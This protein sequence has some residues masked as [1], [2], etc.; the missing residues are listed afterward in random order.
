[1]P[2]RVQTAI[3]LFRDVCTVHKIMI[4]RAEQIKSVSIAEAKL[5]LLVVFLVKID[6]GTEPPCKYPTGRS[7]FRG[8]QFPL[9]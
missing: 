3:F 7:F 4:G 8:T 6:V 1:M 2:I 9:T 5:L